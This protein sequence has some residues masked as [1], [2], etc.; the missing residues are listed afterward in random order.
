MPEIIR[1]RDCILFHKG[2]SLPVTISQDMVNGGWPGSQGVMW[3]DSPIDEFMV[4]YSDGRYAGFLIWGSDETSDQYVSG[5]LTQTYYRS[6]TM[7]FGGNILSTTSYEKYTYASRVG[8]GPLVPITYACNDLLYFS[9]RGLWTNEDE[10][11]LALRPY[12]PAPIVAGC[13]Q[14]P[15]ASNKFYLG[16]QTTQ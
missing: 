11:T 13:V 2:D 3:V 15:K 10:A 12:R 9:L 4:T 1:A 8:G 5:T 14:I 7:M 6:A 16:V